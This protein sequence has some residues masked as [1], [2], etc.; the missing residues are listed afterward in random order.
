MLNKSILNPIID[1]LVS[2]IIYIFKLFDIKLCI[3]SISSS[4]VNAFNLI[5]EPITLVSIWFMYICI[6]NVH[7]TTPF[8]MLN[9]FVDLHSGKHKHAYIYKYLCP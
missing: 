3:K 8:G 9:F 2:K 7:N 6:S 5:T 1:F 4:I